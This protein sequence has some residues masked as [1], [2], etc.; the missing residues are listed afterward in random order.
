LFTFF[1][2]IGCSGYLSGK[3][4]RFEE[5]M[6]TGYADWLGQK[7]GTRLL[8]LDVNGGDDIAYDGF[9]YFSLDKK[10][11]KN[12]I[13]DGHGKENCKFFQIEL[14]YSNNTY[15]IDRGV[16][17]K[18][19]AAYFEGNPEKHFLTNDELKDCLVA[20]AKTMVPFTEYKGDF[21]IPKVVINRGFHKDELDT[22]KQIKN[23]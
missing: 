8:A 6:E 13:I 2:S 5:A 15:V 20:Q 14:K 3:I 19:K 4:G 16:F 18:T 11:F 12:K 1:I 17:E 21:E 23:L 7:G 9:S 22:I 10:P